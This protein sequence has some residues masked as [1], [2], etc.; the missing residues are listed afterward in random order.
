MKP[1]ET[2]A[3]NNRPTDRERAGFCVLRF[4]RGAASGL[5]LAF[6]SSPAF[7]NEE[8]EPVQGS[9]LSDKSP[10][11][12]PGHGE[13]NKPAPPPAPVA[14]GPLS[15]EFEFRGVVQIGSNY[16]FSFFSKKENK[17]Y[18][19]SENTPVSGMNARS[20]DPGNGTV[21]FSKDGRS[22]RLTL[23]S[24]T[25]SPL[26]VALSTNTSESAPPSVRETRSEATPPG[27]D[28]VNTNRRV[29][30]RRRVILPQ[31]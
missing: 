22:E 7:A 26:P 13:S 11:L 24:A 21:I 15:R 29:I 18:W 10:F 12:P 19:I 3:K 17:G 23:M 6:L 4:F 8:A 20:Y 5:L 2:K 30:P 25:D 14:D 9:R 16:Q 1:I 31:K 27:I 28:N